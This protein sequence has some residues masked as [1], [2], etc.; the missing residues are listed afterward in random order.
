MSKL[1]KAQE[2]GELKGTMLIQLIQEH[3]AKCEDPH[4]NISTFYFLEVFE[5]IVGRYA[6]GW[7]MRVFY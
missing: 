7:E 5:N 4:C 3:K 6:K 1:T 2:I